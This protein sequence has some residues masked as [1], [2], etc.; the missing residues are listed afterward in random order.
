MTPGSLDAMLGFVR[1]EGLIAASSRCRI[2]GW[3]ATLMQATINRAFARL[4]AP[5][6]PGFDFL[7]DADAYRAAGYHLDALGETS[8]RRIEDRGLT[9]TLYHYLRLGRLRADY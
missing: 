8:A 7:I 4:S 3:R 1:G 5:V 2:P 6:L 9:G